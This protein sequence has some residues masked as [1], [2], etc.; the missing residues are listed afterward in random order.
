MDAAPPPFVTSSRR[1]MNGDVFSPFAWIPITLQFIVYAIFAGIFGAPAGILSVKF[2]D[3]A[4]RTN[5]ERTRSGGF[6]TAD[7]RL[8]KRKFGES[9]NSARESRAL[10]GIK[11]PLLSHHA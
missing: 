6:Q 4:I 8:R 5:S 7:K 11:N 9:R 3:N 10:P 1:R 2:S